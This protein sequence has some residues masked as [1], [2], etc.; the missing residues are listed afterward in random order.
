MFADRRVV[1][2]RD[3][4]LLDGDPVTLESYAASPPPGSHLL[5]R[6]ESLDQR[7]K[8]GKLLAGSGR[9]FRFDRGSDAERAE[10]PRVAQ[11]M[12]R[13]RG[14]EVGPDVIGFL[15]EAAAGDLYAV[16]SELD[17]LRAWAGGGPGSARVTMEEVR[18]VVSAGATLSG[19]EIADAITVRD[20]RRALTSARRLLAAGEEPLRLLGGIAY[21][22]RA[23]VRAKAMIAGGVPPRGVA[24]RLRMGWGGDAI[25]DGVRRYALEELLAFPYHLAEADRALKSRGIEPGAVL[26]RLVVRLIGAPRRMP[27]V[28]RDGR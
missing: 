11:S 8:M 27:A 4:S 18:Q 5:V 10:F 14:L 7:R 2:V 1:L 16:S 9:W 22:A 24:S 28:R 17:K 25:I 3:W 6:G 19:W 23:M 15:L 13:E 20:G 12:A 26:E 21:R